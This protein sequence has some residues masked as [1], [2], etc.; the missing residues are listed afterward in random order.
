MLVGNSW[1]LPWK[2][3]YAQEHTINFSDYGQF[4]AQPVLVKL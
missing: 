3:N 2:F 1:D 4:D